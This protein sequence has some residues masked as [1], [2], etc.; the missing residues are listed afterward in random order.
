MSDTHLE[1][2]VLLRLLSNG[3]AAASAATQ[4]LLKRLRNAGWLEPTA[5]RDQWTV[6]FGAAD[7]LRARL[8]E[9]C[10]TYEADVKLLTDLG[11]E[12]LSP[13]N[14]ESLPALR[15]P[16]TEQPVLHRKTWNAAAGTGPKH[17]ARV[18]GQALLTDDWVLRIRCTGELTIDFGDVVLDCAKETVARSECTIP[19]RLWLRRRAM[20]IKEI[21]AAITCEN[22]GAFVDLPLPTKMIAIYAPGRDTKPASLFL[23]E[24]P[25]VPWT[26]FGD[27]DQDGIDIAEQIAAQCA[28]PVSLYIPSF[29]GEY[30]DGAQSPRRAWRQRETPWGLVNELERAGLRIQHEAFM[31]DPRLSTDLAAHLSSLR[32]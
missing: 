4:P 21:S 20:A 10:P 31:T 2:T 13:Q 1:V 12:P 26:H 5:R 15:R 19:Q 7:H 6:R 25:G 22:I 16:K 18:A 30:M 28:R 32:S 8:L 29:A 24:L 14:W 23:S 11:L 9:I 3:T 17:Q 27:L